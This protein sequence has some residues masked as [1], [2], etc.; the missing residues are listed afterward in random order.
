MS[1]HAA[2]LALRNAAAKGYFEL[3]MGDIRERLAKLNALVDD[4]LGYNPDEINWS[5]VGSAAHLIEKLD[6]ILETF[7]AKD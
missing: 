6:N 2:A 5:H 4:N 1:I 7:K 3:R